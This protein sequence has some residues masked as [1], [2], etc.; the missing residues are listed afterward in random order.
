MPAQKIE[1]GLRKETFRDFA[2]R[3]SMNFAHFL[4]AWEVESHETRTGRVALHG[5]SSGDPG[6]SQPNGGSESSP[7]GGSHG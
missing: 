5:V 6:Y 7:G 2:R 1:R 3:R 4:A